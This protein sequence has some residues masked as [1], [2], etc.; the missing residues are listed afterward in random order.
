MDRAAC[1][2]GARLRELR[3][4]AGLSKSALARAAGIGR[5][6]I[7]RLERGLHPP[8][9]ETVAR[10]AEALG[11]RPAAFRCPGAGR[12]GAVARPG[13]HRALE[14]VAPLAQVADVPA[15]RPP[16]LTVARDPPPVRPRGVEQVAGVEEPEVPPVPPEDRSHR[17]P[18]ESESRA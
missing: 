10:L 8:D 16:H 11:V 4:R 18:L 5:G 15:V 2:F 9:W 17:R 6:P 3:E 13:A 1:P 14:H 7:A 12:G